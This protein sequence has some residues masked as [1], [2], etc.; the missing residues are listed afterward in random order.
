MLLDVHNL[1][2]TFSNEDQQ[3][4]LVHGVDFSIGEREIVGLVGESGSGKSLTCLSV[5][6]L[7][8]R[9]LTADGSVRY[10]GRELLDL[11]D[12]ERARIRGREITMIFQDPMSALNPVR[13]VANQIVEGLKI[14]EEQPTNRVALRKRA[15]RIMQQVGIPDPE[16]YLKCYPHELSGGLNQ[17]VMIAMMLAGDPHL[18]IADEPTT[19]LDVTVQAQILNLLASLRQER[20]MSIIIITH[21]LGVVVET[22]DRV[23]VMYCGRIVESGPVR[24]IFR[25]P[26]HPYTYG[27]LVALPR[28]DR[29][30]KEL[31][32]IQGQVPMLYALPPG[33]AFAPRCPRATDACARSIPSLSGDHRK[34]ACFNPMDTWEKKGRHDRLS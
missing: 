21:N 28:I 22:C 34:V 9:N 17:R 1:T 19:A 29:P 25:T 3:L 6:G 31:V 33:C 12:E 2:V 16:I 32:P 10:R 5:I 18:L 7:L 27:L 20:G 4:S 30:L 15:I 8:Q 14:N 11:D 26:R 23:S 13:T 24:E